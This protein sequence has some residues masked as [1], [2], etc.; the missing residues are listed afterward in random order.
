MHNS[1]FLDH[2]RIQLS[3]TREA[4]WRS[5]LFEDK[6]PSL[7]SPQSPPI[8]MTR[9]LDYSKWDHIEVSTPNYIYVQ[10]VSVQSISWMKGKVLRKPLANILTRYSSHPLSESVRESFVSLYEHSAEKCHFDPCPIDRSVTMR[11]TH[12]P[13][14]THRRCFDGDTKLAL[15]G[16]KSRRRRGP[17]WP[18]RR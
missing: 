7:N 2:C 6:C 17:H 4:V 14:L 18:R 8:N 12:I 10:R 3:Q 15:K 11:T 9:R 1:G 5:A 16:W 13:T